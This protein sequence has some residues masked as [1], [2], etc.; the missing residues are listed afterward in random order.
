M[1]D[2]RSKVKKRFADEG[3]CIADWARRHG[4][5]RKLVYRVLDGSAKGLRGKAHNIAV[6]LGI[7]PAVPRPQFR[8][9]SEAD[10]A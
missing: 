8:S 4:F 1:A 6:A 7:K 10:A 9:A 5:E 3:V 2:I